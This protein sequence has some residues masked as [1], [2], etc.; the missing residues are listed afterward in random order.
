MTQAQ[1]A[2]PLS[3]DEPVAQTSLVLDVA[4][5]IATR[6]SI[7]EPVDR[8]SIKA[9][10]ADVTGGSDANGDW[11]VKDF[12]HAV[13]AAII[14]AIQSMSTELGALDSSAMRAKIDAITQLLPRRNVR[15]LDQMALQQ[16][17][18]PPWLGGLMAKL[19]ALQPND[20]VLEPSAGTGMLAVWAK[21]KGSVLHL[22]EIDPDRRVILGAL[23]PD[24]RLTGFDGELID[25]FVPSPE[26][27]DVVLMNP[28]F[29]RSRER[30]D[31]GQAAMRHL[32]SAL[33]LAKPGAR[34]VAIMPDGFKARRFAASQ[35]MASLLVDARIEQAFT[36]R[37]TAIP[38][39]LVVIDKAARYH[40][41]PIAAPITFRDWE[42]VLDALPSRFEAGSKKVAQPIAANGPSLSVSP[43]LRRFEAPFARNRQSQSQGQ[44]LAYTSLQEPAPMASQSGLYLDYRPSRITIADA[45]VHPTPLVESLAM[46]SVA[47]PKIQVKVQLPR[48]WQERALLSQPQCETVLYAN[49]A[50]ALDLGG[51]FCPSEDGL[52]LEPTTEGFRYRQGFFLGDGTGAGKGRQIAAVIMS[53]W[54]EGHRRHIWVSKNEA[55]LEDARRD[56]Q[57]LGGLGP[58]IQ[59]LS[60]WK[61]GRPL[62]LDSGIVFVTYPTLRSGRIDYTRLAQ[63]LEWAGETFE[64][65]IAFDEAHAMANAL[66][67]HS[68]R[69]KVKGSE[70]GIAGVRL[71]NALPR[72]RVLY[73]SATGASDV[74]NLAYATRLGLWGP[75]TAFASAHEFVEEIRAGG[76]AAM[77]LVARD[78]KAQGLYLA[79][80][81]SFAGVEY[82]MLVHELTD[83]QIRIYDA[84]SEAWSIIHHNL[85]AALEA[86][87][88]V[89]EDNKDTL[90]RNAKAAALS[91]FEG[92]KQRFFAQLLLSMKLPSLFP[93]IE[94]ALSADH[95]V[96][97]QLVSTSEAMLD[98][99]LADLSDEERAALDIDL[100][101]REYVVDYLMKSFPVRLMQVF[102]DEEGHVRSEPMS[103]AA[104]NPVLCPRAVA[105][106]ARLVEQLCALPPIA[107]ALDAIIARFGTAKVAE[108]TGRTRRLVQDAR[109][110]QKLENRSARSNLTEASAFMNG[111]KR[112]L[113]FSDAGGTGR[114]Y[115][116]DLGAKN[117]QRRVHFLLEPGW[118]ADAAIQGL[119]RTNRTN[120][121]H[122]P[123]FRPVTTNVKGERRFISTIARR[124]DALGAL[125]RGQRQTGGQ[126][127]F[128][129][130][131]NLESDFAKDAL[132]RW[133]HLLFEGKLTAITMDEF[134]AKTGLKLE[135]PDGCLID[136]LPPI[137]RWL[138]RLLAL[139]IA[140]QNAI[141]EEYQALIEARVE[142]A[143]AAGTLDLGIETLAV[144]DFHI[145]KN[146]VV[147]TDPRTG[148][149]THLLSLDISR[150]LKPLHYSQL[151]KL[152]DV[153]SPRSAPLR[154]SKSG[155]VALRVSAK[156]MLT[157]EGEL[158]ARYR[159]I[160]PLKAGYWK[161]EVLAASDWEP[162]S[163]GL[164]QELWQAEV[165]DAARTTLKEQ[166]FLATGLLLPVWKA[167]GEDRVRVTRLE[168]KDGRSLIGRLIDAADI[169][170]VAK[171]FGVD[172]PVGLEPSAIAVHV[173]TTGKPLDFK[174]YDQLVV[175][176]SLVNGEQRLELTGFSPA[177]LDWYRTKGCFAEIIR[178]RTRLFVPV[179][180]ASKI[181]EMLATG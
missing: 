165:D 12:G 180:L 160:T 51:T 46:G 155:A 121:A 117:Q 161:Q 5:R 2:L 23:F 26:A 120:Q 181:L 100:S 107:A 1:S 62:T 94:E 95:S 123:M 162:I 65:V 98:R 131:D 47:A 75:E 154:N 166:M 78:L 124:L 50:F 126:N 59:P 133:F 147:R 39:R 74:A 7:N 77:E 157:E 137:Q 79:R 168:S 19:A 108:V 35:E 81:L 90:N 125:T 159:L 41:E 136:T 115:H 55:L 85:E 104:G 84:Y 110:Q 113:V 91:I 68:V 96:V 83:T 169:A 69:G 93:A 37:G 146:H 130:A 106:R 116:A 60:S 156:S 97:V 143:R 92:T 66:G 105:A 67:G 17:S 22:N 139:P 44:I 24:S 9:M 145:S 58:D 71:Q 76:V 11:S 15:S 158:V 52:S 20:A 150:R 21:L 14:L 171:Q 13:E 36:E 80:A 43:S 112:I 49:A 175:K 114:S 149:T 111:S 29:A 40:G 86:T 132:V 25:Q 140:L 179:K 170:A 16:F 148:A 8:S 102:T 88:I 33:R 103:D 135:T 54:L 134:C 127:L 144:D 87:R 10:F 53:Q 151:T 61:L 31:D 164:F 152:H 142:A 141:F 27:P 18:T 38:T 32:R 57:A 174:S 178:Y 3:F 82:D 42:Q 45:P 56:W 172:G 34:I 153:T 4:R 101:P 30:G 70:Q 99:R 167:L 73:A 163:Q 72:A 122:P 48:Q 176:R 89:D 129:P 173:M 63:I 28:P 109:G 128:D 138:N 6:L 118:R 119:G 177:R 64:G